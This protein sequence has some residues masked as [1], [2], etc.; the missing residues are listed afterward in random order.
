MLAVLPLVVVTA[1]FKFVILV[2]IAVYLII[3][4]VEIQRKSPTGFSE[5]TQGA[6]VYRDWLQEDGGGGELILMWCLVFP[7]G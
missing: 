2:A 6:L 4:F 3:G 5:A 1:L 7:A